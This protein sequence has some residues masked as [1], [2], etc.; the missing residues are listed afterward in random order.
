MRLLPTLTAALAAALLAPA[1]GFADDPPTAKLNKKITGVTVTDPAGKSA[2]LDAVAGKVLVPK[3]KQA[4]M[5]DLLDRLV[6]EKGG[7]WKRGEER[8]G[9]R[10]AEVLVGDLEVPYT[11]EATF[12]GADHYLI[13]FNQKAAPPVAAA[14]LATTAD[15]L[16]SAEIASIVANAP[17]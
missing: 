10:P 7:S 11:G 17:A 5:K 14:V 1:P 3:A 12:G 13:S 2:S 9:D 6:A 16:S 15:A 8:A 4:Q